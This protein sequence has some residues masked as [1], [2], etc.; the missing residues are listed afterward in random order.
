MNRPL[1]L[2]AATMR[3]AKLDP[4]SPRQWARWT[5]ASKDGAGV[6]YRGVLTDDGVVLLTGGGFR[7]PVHCQYDVL[8]ILRTIALDIARRHPDLNLDADELARDAM[9]TVGARMRAQRAWSVSE[10]EVV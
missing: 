5:L 1:P 6:I 4:E 7:A 3:A 10:L 2:S 8:T 9:A